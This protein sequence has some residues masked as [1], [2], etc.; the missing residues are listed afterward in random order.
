MLNEENEKTNEGIFLCNKKKRDK[1]L[2]FGF[3]NENVSNSRGAHKVMVL[4]PR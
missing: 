1:N 2:Q 4:C 3:D